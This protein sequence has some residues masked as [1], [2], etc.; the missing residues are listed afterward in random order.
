MVSLLLVYLDPVPA[1]AESA[2]PWALRFPTGG[3]SKRGVDP[4]SAL[5]AASDC[6]LVLPY[7]RI[8]L[9]RKKLPTVRREKLQGAL[10]YAVE[11]ASLG[12]PASTYVAFAGEEREGLSSLVAVERQAFSG[13]L[14]ALRERGLQPSRMIAETLTPPLVQQGWTVVMRD[15]GG[16]ARTAAHSG[17]S[18][19]LGTPDSPP[20]QL[21]LALAE[22][23]GAGAAPAR[24]RVHRGE[25]VPQLGSWR[26]ALGID[27]DEAGAWSWET[28]DIQA[29]P[30]LLQGELRARSNRLESL[31]PWFP[32]AALAGMIL[33]VHIVFT[34][35]QWGSLVWERSS[36]T[37]EMAAVFRQAVPQA[38]AMVNPPLQMR[39]LLAELRRASGTLTGDDFLALL[40]RAAPEV[41]RA[42]GANVR[43]IE[44]ASGVLR[45]ELAVPGAQS[46]PE[47]VARLKEAGLSAKLETSSASGPMT[48]ARIAI[49][50]RAP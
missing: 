40:G 2:F 12:D 32:A 16:F 7:H 45:V 3:V 35:L 11:D 14:H 13:A 39:R 50:D 36:L 10:Y 18:M 29:T 41:E 8:T 31:R 26:A 25:T 1:G 22:A 19:D 43:M 21:R 4:I 23:R 47:I 49:S 15:G 37:R 9:H 5:P 44:Y 46:A 6:V 20:V 38:Q 33:V 34:L 27:I 28:A 17:F 48:V 24:L 42:Q 30:D